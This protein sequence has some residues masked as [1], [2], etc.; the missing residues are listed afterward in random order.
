MASIRTASGALRSGASFWSLRRSFAASARKTAPPEISP[1]PV[2]FAGHH[3]LVALGVDAKG[4]KRVLGILEGASENRSWRWP[5]SR[6]LSSGAW[7]RARA[8]IGYRDLWVLKAH[9]DELT[10]PVARRVRSRR[11][12]PEE[13]VT[14]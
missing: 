4:K 3:V 13:E 2:Q 8:I 1:A 6:S 14:S 12:L 7:P 10:T 5:C 11:R 9:L